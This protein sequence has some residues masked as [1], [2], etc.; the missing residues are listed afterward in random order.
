MTSSVVSK[1]TP[2]LPLLSLAFEAAL[3]MGA[4]GLLI[5]PEGPIDW[6]LVRMAALR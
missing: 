6:D 1:A 3:R 4:T 5:L 2:P